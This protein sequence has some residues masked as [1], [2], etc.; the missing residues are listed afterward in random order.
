[1]PMLL[2]ASDY[3]RRARQFL[4]RGLFEYIDRGSEDETAL[5]RLRDSLDAMT[6]L[7]A[8]LTGHDRRDLDTVLFGRTIAAPLVVAPTALAG[9]VSHDGE[10]KLAR[11]AA[12]VGIPVCISTQSVT[13]VEA[14]R[15]GAPDALLWFQLYVWRDR[16]LTARL[17]ERA[18][19]CGCDNLLVT[20][21]TP[22][23]PNREYNERN[24]FGIPFKPR[25]RSMIDVALHPAWLFGVLVRYLMGEGVPTYG[26][27][28]EAF[29]T[30]ITR[31]EIAEAVRLENRLSWDD[32]RWLRGIWPGKLTIKGVLAVE[33]AEKA[34]EI[35]ADGIVVSVH[36]GRNLDCLPA[37]VDCI[38]AIVGAVKGR[39]T[40]LADSGV[41]RGTDV[42]KYL[43]L[44]AEA[45]LLGRLP[46]WGLA[47]GGEAGAEAVLRMVL[48]EMDTA[49]AFLGAHCVPALRNGRASELRN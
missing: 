36:G 25:L 49:M 32:M 1:M 9:L 22:V 31:A 21:D 18:S 16:A 48:R 45:V 11:A 43:A 24:G 47:V 2:N 12:R 6:L 38:P 33:D 30:A 3:R 28:P 27:Y 37:P 13:S 5:T 40:I 8:V 41:R 7:P 19:A 34:V 44:G 4:P 15:R 23:S 14:I 26:H 10:T 42:L 29:R 46:L 20:V 39:L 17:L 35:G